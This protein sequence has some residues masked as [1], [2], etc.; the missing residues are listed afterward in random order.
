[1]FGWCFE[2]EQNPY[3]DAVLGAIEDGRA[4]ALALA[5]LDRELAAAAEAAGGTI[6][7][8]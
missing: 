3:C 6:F 8:P 7:R 1:V 2:D 5:T 4:L